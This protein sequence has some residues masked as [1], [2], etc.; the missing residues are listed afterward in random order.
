MS[1]VG[2]FDL[3]GPTGPTGS[4]GPTGTAGSTGS[5]GVKGDTGPTGA[6]IYTAIVFDGGSS[7]ST[8]P[9][10]PAFDCGTSQ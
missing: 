5:T 10:G 8:Y 2:G 7:T 9:N 6:V 3:I 1:W 4:T